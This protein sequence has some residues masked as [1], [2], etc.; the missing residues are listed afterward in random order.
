M[1]TPVYLNQPV[2]RIPRIRR[3]IGR[4]QLRLLPHQIAIEIVGIAI[5]AVFADFVGFVVHAGIERSPVPSLV[6]SK[7]LV[8]HRGQGRLHGG[9]AIVGIV[10]KG[11]DVAIGG[12]PSHDIAGGVVQVGV[13][14][15]RHPGSCIVRFIR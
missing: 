8:L 1:L 5:T 2:Q 7:G 4:V 14:A 10:G 11:P 6:V 15:Q 9:Q 3:H 13:V 12:S